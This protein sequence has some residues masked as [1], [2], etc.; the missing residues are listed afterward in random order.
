MATLGQVGAHPAR[1]AADVEGCASAPAQ[2]HAVGRAG[3]T[4]PFVHGDDVVT[5]VDPAHRGR[6]PAERVAEQLGEGAG[7]FD[8]HRQLRAKRVS[9]APAAT[10][11]GVLDLVHVAEALDLG[12]ACAGPGQ[13]LAGQRPGLRGGHRHL[14]QVRDQARAG[15][16]EEPP[17][18]VVGRAKDCRVGAGEQCPGLEQCLRGQVRGVHADLDDGRA[19]RSRSVLVG[20]DESLG[21][22]LATLGVKGPVGSG[23]EELFGKLPVC[24]D[25]VEGEVASFGAVRRSADLHRV[26]QRSGC[27]VCGALHANLAAEPGL[28]VPDDR[29]LGDDEHHRAVHASAAHASAVHDR[30]AAKS[31][32]ARIVPST[33]P[34]TFDRVP[35][36]RG[37]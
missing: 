26:E 22:P 1:T 18:S 17:A 13:R 28:D 21:E 4:Q 8:G 2:Q 19:R 12:H 9:G 32:A 29:R 16:P 25:T 14:G 23:V 33:E 27:Q 11:L 3:R 37:W 5:W 35:S 24:E 36:A 6:Y 20:V 10:R 30:T 7:A 34:D 31:R 15:D